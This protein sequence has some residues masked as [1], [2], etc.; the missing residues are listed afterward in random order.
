MF[1]VLYHRVFVRC[2]F[3]RQEAQ[4]WEVRGG[5]LHLFDFIKVRACFLQAR[6]SYCLT[7]LVGFLRSDSYSANG[8]ASNW[9]ALL[10][11][12]VVVGGGYK[13]EVDNPTLTKPP[14]GCDSVSAVVRRMFDELLMRSQVLGEPGTRL[15]YDELVVYDNDAIQP[16]YLV[17]Y[18]VP[19]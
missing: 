2:G 6:W 10:L 19:K 14:A 9:K 11:N 1:L 7:V 4:L 13:M 16:S 15:N 8:R 12:K 18:D 5:D 17:M 3:F